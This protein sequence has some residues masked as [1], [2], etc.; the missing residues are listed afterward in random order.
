M[1]I[2]VQQEVLAIT[3]PA[4]TSP[5]HPADNPW[6]LCYLKQLWQDNLKKFFE[7]LLHLE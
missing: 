2:Q 1:F 5:G 6:K 7:Q 3:P 4:Y